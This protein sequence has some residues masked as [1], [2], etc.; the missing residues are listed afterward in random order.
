MKMS[1]HLNKISPLSALTRCLLLAT[2]SLSALLAGC[3]KEEH[4]PP[5]VQGNVPISFDATT[6]PMK[7]ASRAETTTDNILSMRVFASYTKGA[8]FGTSSPMNYMYNQEV[9]RTNN[10][11]PWKY[12]PV[13]Y[14]P[15]KEGEKISFFAYGYGYSNTPYVHGGIKLSPNT[16]IG[17]PYIDFKEGKYS[18][19][20]LVCATVKNKT[21]SSSGG[22]VSFEMKH[23]MT[24][25]KVS[26]VNKDKVAN[27]NLIHFGIGKH[28]DGRYSFADDSW[29]ILGTPSRTNHSPDGISW[30]KSVPSNGTALELLPHYYFVPT[31]NMPDAMRPDFAIYYTAPGSTGALETI[32][33]DGQPLPSTDKWLAG[34]YLSYKIVIEKQKLTVTASAHPTWT[35]AGTGTVVGTLAIVYAVNPSEP[36]WGNGGKGEIDGVPVVTHTV[37]PG[38]IPWVSRDPEIIEVTP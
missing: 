31:G 8:D 26:V 11:S 27:M 22:N 7:P 21:S 12:S 30:P 28:G 10:T 13:K 18:S 23:V 4:Q 20:D 9:T 32:K 14:W 15:N 24:R 6:L 17:Y 16:A 29:S 3:D 36:S 19:T 2:L 33:L 35:D 37:Q 25:I 1:K 38:E 34:A 5:M